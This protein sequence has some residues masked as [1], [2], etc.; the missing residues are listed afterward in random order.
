MNR[1]TPFLWLNG[2]VEEAMT[3]YRDV[4]PDLTVSG[5]SMGPNGKMMTATF[6]LEGQRF[7]AFD[8]GPH[9][10]LTPA[11]SIYVNCESQAEVDEIWDKLVAGGSASRCGWLQDRFG[12]SWQ[13]IPS[14]LP[15]LL[16]D[17]D[18]VKADRAMQA[19][20]QMQKIDVA[21]LEQAFD[22]E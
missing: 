12:V 16:R 22:G 8:G 9:Y 19:M 20:L 2:N 14:V 13:V 1:I 18:R 3:L 17:P 21:A 10:Q 4:F 11:F 5:T 15:K 6:E 7:I